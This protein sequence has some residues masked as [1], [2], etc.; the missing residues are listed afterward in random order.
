[1]KI[2]GSVAVV[3]GAAQ[4]IGKAYCEALLSKGG[5]VRVFIWKSLVTF[6]FNSV[7]VRVGST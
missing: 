5:K 3:L 1:M 2:E 4:G 6:K 7:K